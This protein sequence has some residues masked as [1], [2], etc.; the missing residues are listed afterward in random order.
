MKNLLTY[1]LIYTL[2]GCISI[3]PRKISIIFGKGLG[4]FLNVLFPIRKK[5]AR[6][7]L[8]IAFPNK[9]IIEINRII[10]KD[11]WKSPIVKT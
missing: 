7:N 1:S 5:V 10:T 3:L 11:V 2:S 8:Q 9:S 4:N 6:Y